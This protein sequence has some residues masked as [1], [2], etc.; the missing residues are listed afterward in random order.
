MMSWP[1]RESPYR[2]YKI[3]W[4]SEIQQI[5]VKSDCEFVEEC[6]SY[7]IVIATVGHIVD[8]RSII[9]V[10]AYELQFLFRQ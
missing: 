6:T 2:L 4:L 3:I 10:I 8:Y 9:V 7:V 5:D 1:T